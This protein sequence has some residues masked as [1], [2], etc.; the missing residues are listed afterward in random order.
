MGRA[1]RGRKGCA[2][3]RRKTGLTPS[4]PV[5]ACNAARAMRSGSHLDVC[6]AAQ[7][8]GRPR[9]GRRREAP[10]CCLSLCF[11]LASRVKRDRRYRAALLSARGPSKRSLLSSHATQAAAWAPPPKCACPAPSP[12][13]PEPDYS[14][15]G[16]RRSPP[17]PH[18]P[19][20]LPALAG[21]R[22][23]VPQHRSWTLSSTF[24][25]HPA[26]G[27][28]SGRVSH[29]PPGPPAPPAAAPPYGSSAAAL[30]GRD[31]VCAQLGAHQ[32][33][34]HRGPGLREGR[35]SSAGHGRREG[36]LLLRLHGMPWQCR[37]RPTIGQQPVPQLTAG[38]TS[39]PR[40]G[41]HCP[42][43]GHH[44]ALLPAG[45]PLAWHWL[46]RMQQ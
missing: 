19:G 37:R 42:P 41:R 40:A 38:L 22:P 35:G 46:I 31:G 43:A 8:P 15:G 9:A 32:G 16:T 21:Q 18:P 2:L 1:V 39:P 36:R 4:P 20:Q 12:S 7:A 5:Q 17:T 10:G 26:A 24:S 30:A 23:Q 29:A 45:A 6:P 11:E 34:A 3:R 25:A 33:R 28:P 44:A 13:V 27:K 14:H